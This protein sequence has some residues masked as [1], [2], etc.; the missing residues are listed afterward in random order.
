M[1]KIQYVCCTV[2][3]TVSS[4]DRTIKTMLFH[5]SFAYAMKN[6]VLLLHILQWKSFVPTCT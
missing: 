1:E 2:S 4:D 5:Q 3:C 6:P